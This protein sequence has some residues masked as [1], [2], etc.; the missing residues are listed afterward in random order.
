[1]TNRWS[2]LSLTLS[3][4]AGGTDAFA[5]EF[6]ILHSESFVGLRAEDLGMSNAA[7]DRLAGG[8]LSFEAYGRR[9]D[10]QLE[11]NERLLSRLPDA[12]REALQ[13]FPIFRGRVAGLARSWVRLTRVGSELHGMIWDG[14]ELYV[15]EP[16]QT[17]AAFM[18]APVT[19]ARATNVVYRLSDT[20]SD[21]G[22]DF[23]A[24]R[25]VPGAKPTGLASYQALV[26]ELRQTAALAAPTG[27]MQVAVIGDFEFVTDNPTNTQAV[28]LARMNTVDGIFS[29]QVGVRLTVPSVT[30]FSTA[31]DPFTDT[32]ESDVLI[33][34]L[35]DYKSGTPAIRNSGVAHLMTGRNFDGSTVGIAFLS[36]ICNSRFGVSLS[37][38]GSEISSTSA[39]L[40]AA[41]E[42]GHNFGAPHDAEV[43]TACESTPPTFLMAPQLNGSDQF[44][45]CSLS[46]M[47]PVIDAASCIAP[48][49]FSD[50]ALTVAPAAINSQVDQ[51][52][53]FA[54]NV[55]S[56]GTQQVIG[57]IVTI[58]VPAAI[59]VNSAVPTVGSCSNGAGTVTC[60]L[61]NLPGNSSQRI[62]FS[63]R[64]TQAGSFTSTAT[65]ASSTDNNAQ[66]NDADVTFTVTATTPPPGN[67]G[68][69][70][71][72]G[73]G[74]L[75]LCA[76]LLGA[77][78]H[79]ARG[80]KIT[81]TAAV[82]P[83]S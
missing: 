5:A 45:P 73:L 46:Q 7:R 59:T 38:G 17:A 77:G 82:C 72:G 71:G 35:S 67:G 18:V 63:V 34:E 76:L 25:T 61:G 83:D 80:F 69:G 42:I 30:L 79:F 49:A 56:V 21:L 12:Q 40:V 64:T 26:A 74:W 39:T 60:D 27:E 31:S 15:I 22:P 47:Q 2:T 1:M 9:F 81:E 43:G 78:R 11:P 10:L 54:V 20:L 6:R 41:H 14:S 4:L 66:N 62:D 50:A 37:E 36:S 68:G 33:D 32:T 13:K 16:M 23:C 29:D 28:V 57:A 75:T 48:L 44:S 24:V 70:G 8:A 3:L 53:T 51:S 52:V 58:T 55:N 19:G 65:L